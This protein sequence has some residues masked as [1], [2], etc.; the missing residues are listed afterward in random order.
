[1]VGGRRARDRAADH[2]GVVEERR[3]VEVGRV[4]RHGVGRN[5]PE[6]GIGPAAALHLQ[7]GQVVPGIARDD[8]G[9]QGTDAPPEHLD[10][11]CAPGD[12]VRGRHD[13]AVGIGEPSRSLEAPLDEDLHGRGPRAGVQPP[14][15]RRRGTPRSAEE[16]EQAPP[17]GV[18]P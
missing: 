13:K 7:Q 10:A 3:P 6:G 8:A 5:H 9:R 16:Q 1:M 11:P 18:S 4:A 2:D 15:S 17:F 14:V 12:D